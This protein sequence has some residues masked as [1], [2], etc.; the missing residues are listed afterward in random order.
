EKIWPEPSGKEV[1]KSHHE[2]CGKFKR[3]PT[4]VLTLKVD[5]RKNIRRIIIDDMRWLRCIAAESVVDRLV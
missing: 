2:N 3:D 4:P 5:H 1:L